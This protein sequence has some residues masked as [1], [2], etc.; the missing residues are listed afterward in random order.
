MK[1][2]LLFIIC[3][4]LNVVMQTIKSLLT[5]KCGKL[6]ASIINAVA[7]GFYTYIIILTNVDLPTMLK[8]VIVASANFIG[9]YV[10]KWIEEKMRKEKLWK[11]EMTIPKS[12][13]N[14]LLA[15]EEMQNISYSLN[16]INEKYDRIDFYSYT[17]QESRAV[18]ELAKEFGAKTFA[19]ASVSL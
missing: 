8:C 1:L 6:P 14:A 18:R 17:Q 16:H 3:N 10:V 19:S 4:V 9:V 11:I 2:L 12:K 13:V 7:Y 15:R 5:I